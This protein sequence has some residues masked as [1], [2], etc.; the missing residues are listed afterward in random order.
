MISASDSQ[1]GGPGFESHALYLFSVVP[2][3]N[4]RP[5][6]CLLAVGVF[7]PVYVVFELFVSK[8]LSGVLR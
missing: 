3:S 6:G 8:Y 4:P 1:S 7:D 5:T 2:R